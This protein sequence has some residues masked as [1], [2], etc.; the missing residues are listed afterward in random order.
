[1]FVD[2]PN[3]E[4]RLV[5]SVEQRLHILISNFPKVNSLVIHCP[6]VGQN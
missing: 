2:S 5:L 3:V 4:V 1:M 6:V